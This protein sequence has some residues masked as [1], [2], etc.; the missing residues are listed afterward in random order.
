MKPY[1]VTAAWLLLPDGSIRL[2]MGS[3]IDTR[4]PSV[5]ISAAEW[6]DRLKGGANFRFFEFIGDALHEIQ[7][8]PVHASVEEGKRTI[9]WLLAARPWDSRRLEELADSAGGRLMLTGERHLSDARPDEELEAWMPFQDHRGRAIA[10]LDFHVAEPLEED[11]ALEKMELTLFLV[12]GGAALLL[13]G[14]LLQAWVLRPFALVGASLRSRDPG[15]LASLLPKQDEFGDMARTVQ[16]ALADRAQLKQS[17]EERIRLGRELHDGAIQGV[18]ASGLALS[19]AQS[20]INRNVPE[21]HQLLEET[22]AE[23]N[24]IIWDLRRQIEQ[25]DPAQAR[26]DFGEAVRRIVRL[27]SG[28]DEVTTTIDVDE[29]LVAL[30]SPLHRG[31]ALQFVR[32]GVSNAIRHGRPKHLSVSWQQEGNGSLL[33]IID[34]GVGFD[35]LAI[36]SAGRGLGNLH[37]RAV[38]LGGTLA[39]SSSPS[40]GTRLSLKLPM[41]GGPL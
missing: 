22:K 34:D 8:V 18:Y 37:E 20:L 3:Q 12:N 7:G 14:V 17:L 29:D 31:Q 27:F 10:G 6:V 5:P 11:P 4:A 26:E 33:L 9:G 15:P 23:L 38:N 40:K 28:P 1:E 39:I 13:I 32:E 25:A 19:R 41:L 2:A 36:A 35:P 24:R 16:S 21:A 30:Y